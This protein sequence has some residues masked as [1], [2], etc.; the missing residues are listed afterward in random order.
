MKRNRRPGPIALV[1]AAVASLLLAACTTNPEEPAST[2]TTVSKRAGSWMESLYKDHPGTTLGSI[3]IPGTHDSGTGGI[4]TET[5]CKNSEI[6]GTIEP[7]FILGDVEPCMLAGFSRTQD[8]DLYT[9][10]SSGIRYLDMRVGVPADTALKPADSPIPLPK[11]PL[12]VE[13]VTEHTVVSQRLSVALDGILAFAQEHP[14]EQVILDFQHV[15]L[16]DNPQLAAYYREI[17]TRYLHD[18]VPAGREGAVPVCS[19]AWS[20]D[21]ITAADKDLARKVSFG[22]A[23]EKGRNLIVLTAPGSDPDGL[24]ATPCYRNRTEA[25]LSQWPKTQDP[26]VSATYNKAEL[27][28]RGKKLAANPQQC[29]GKQS[30]GANADGTPKPGTDPA[31]W[32]GFFVNQMQLSIGGKTYAAC[33]VRPHASC[34]LFALSQTVN[35]AVPNEVKSWAEAG[36]PANIV[37]VDF[38]NYA[39]PSYVETLLDLNEKALG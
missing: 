30:I 25:I 28:Q 24:P 32:C 29:A 34:S 13:L 26:Q 7:I 2:P 18:Y 37:I 1:A 9:Q 12:S 20:S 21:V 27:E 3:L 16:P 11:N 10:L 15:N 17:L 8:V 35:N 38:F 23:W 4:D 6:A 31:N 5:P 33:V 19:R 36:L 14:K 39:V 22:E